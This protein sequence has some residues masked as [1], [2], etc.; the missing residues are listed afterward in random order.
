MRIQTETARIKSLNTLLDQVGIA[1]H[2]YEIFVD[3]TEEILKRTL[4]AIQSGVQDESFLVDAFNEGYSA[5]AV[6][7]HF[8]VRIFAGVFCWIF[9]G[10]LISGFLGFLHS[11]NAC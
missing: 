2:I 1:D 8:R 7:T 3:A 9:V 5:D 11:M 4:D 10:F 6:I